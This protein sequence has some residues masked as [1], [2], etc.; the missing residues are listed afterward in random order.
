[1]KRAITWSLGILI[2]SIL[3]YTGWNCFVTPNFLMGE[4]NRVSGKVIE[5]FPSK[6]VK[7]Y[8]RRIKYVYSVNDKDYVDFKK[9]GTND[10]KQA[11]GNHLKIVYSV[12]H[13]EWNKVEKHL[14]N[15][16]NSKG[17]KFYSNTD[18]GY[19]EM[20]LING[21]FK[22]KE[23]RNG[24]EVLNNFTGEY[25]FSNDS[26]LFKH[27]QFDPLA[28]VNSRPKFF[29]VDSNNNHHL[30]ETESKSVFKKIVKK[31]Y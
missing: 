10:E 8:S 7:S 16:R 22:Y 1:M 25:S 21:I 6:E 17:V 14:N 30:I 5:V 2:G 15:Y 4:T 26:V 23:Y 31:R 12:N 20:R 13:P 11:I 19:I 24:G 3:F 27:Y 18:K 28:K 9:L 29:V